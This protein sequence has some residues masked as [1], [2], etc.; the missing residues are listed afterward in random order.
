MQKHRITIN[1]SLYKE[2][3]EFCK[4]NNLKLTEFCNILLKKSLLIEKY[5][6]T[7]FVSY[8]N[9]VNTNQECYNDDNASKIEEEK[10]CMNNFSEKNDLS[11]I[12]P[13][14]PIKRKLK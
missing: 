6:E 8:N 14:G 4:L 11:K 2:L 1:D 12:M 13:N 7:P 5:G 10:I 9:N 3:Y